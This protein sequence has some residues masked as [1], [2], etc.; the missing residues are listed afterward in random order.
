MAKK[1]ICRVCKKGIKQRKGPGRPKTTHDRCKGKKK[2]PR[3]KS[4]KKKSTK[5]KV[6]TTKKKTT[7]KKT[8]KRAKTTRRGSSVT[9][10]RQG[11]EIVGPSGW[12]ALYHG[13][14]TGKTQ[15]DKTWAVKI[16]KR[17]SRYR[18]LTRHGRRTGQK[19]VTKHPL[20]SLDKAVSKA[21]RLLSSKIRK[22][23]AFVGANRKRK[24][25]RRR[26]HKSRRT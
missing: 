8:L 1:H 17:G 15:H 16:E 26:R 6:K 18:V 12:V 19:N 13:G 9:K 2:T 22:G 3:K 23:Y 25:R 7:K 20:T 5:K 21:N 11:R 14:Q 4:T 24:T 10:S